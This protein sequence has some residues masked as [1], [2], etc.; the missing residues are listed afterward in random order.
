[1]VVLNKKDIHAIADSRFSRKFWIWGVLSIIAILG[2][3][4]GIE[5]VES[6]LLQQIM[7]WVSLILMAGTAF[8]LFYFQRKMRKKLFSEVMTENKLEYQEKV[9]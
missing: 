6:T 2:L 9:E 7:A 3:N 8:C 1:M 4:Y 5:Y